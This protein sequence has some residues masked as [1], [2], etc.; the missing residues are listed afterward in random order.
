MYLSFWSDNSFD[1]QLIKKII[2][3]L[4]NKF[5]EK[6]DEREGRKESGKRDMRES[7]TKGG[8]RD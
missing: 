3:R 7:G 4:F 8:K 1:D 5:R 2:F 6:M